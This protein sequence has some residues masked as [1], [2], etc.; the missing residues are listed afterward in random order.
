MKKWKI[1]KL[2]LEGECRGTTSIAYV[3]YDPTLNGIFGADTR[4][5]K[6]I[7]KEQQS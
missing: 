1:W 6:I 2:W 5:F 4:R 7:W 3:S